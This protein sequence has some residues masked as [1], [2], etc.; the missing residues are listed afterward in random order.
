MVRT[1]VPQA[2]EAGD[3]AP[4]RTV[5]FRIHADEISERA[6]RRPRVQDR[7]A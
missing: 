1:L 4:H 3:P 2:L 6:A 7:E 5:P